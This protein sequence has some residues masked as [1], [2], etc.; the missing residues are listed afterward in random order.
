M[1]LL[2][3]GPIPSFW[4][5][6]GLCFRNSHLLF[7]LWMSVNEREE[8]SSAIGKTRPMTLGGGPQLDGSVTPTLTV[9][10]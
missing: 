5:A 4:C 8:A 3:P 9:S 7:A 10:L 1:T 2:S 6:F